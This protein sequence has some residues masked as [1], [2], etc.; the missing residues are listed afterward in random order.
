MA[1]MSEQLLSVLR[2][3]VTGSTLV[4]EGEELVS[5]A[6]GPDGQPVRYAIDEGIALLLRPEQLE[7]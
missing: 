3:P 6:P 1:K 7:G 4:Q 5:T 2:C